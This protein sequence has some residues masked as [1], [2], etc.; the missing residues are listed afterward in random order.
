[1]ACCAPS[2]ST[3]AELAYGLWLAWLNALGQL[4]P[5]VPAGARVTPER[6]DA[7]VDFLR[8]TGNGP[9]SVGFRLGKLSAALDTIAPHGVTERSW[10]RRLAS[11]FPQRKSEERGLELATKVSSRDLFDL[12][13]RLMAEAEELAA[14][15]RARTGSRAAVLHRDGLM[16]ALQSLLA[17]RPSNLLA[18]EDGATLRRGGDADRAQGPAGWRASFAGPQMKAGRRHGSPIP[19]ELAQHIQHH[20]AVHRPRLVAAARPGTAETRT[21]FVSDRGLPLGPAQDWAAVTKRV[22]AALG[23]SVSIHEFRHVLASTVAIDAP[24]MMGVVPGALGHADERPVLD[25]YDLATQLEAGR[26]WGDT[27]ASERGDAVAAFLRRVDRRL[28]E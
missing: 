24:Q 2:T 20:M 1:M 13:L 6:I 7:F 14:R 3:A 21:L 26:R 5:Q 16:I 8:A 10:L 28:K 9:A 15:P 27:V 18:L 12:G 23:V 11:S 17:L 25:H 19:E 4:D 22:K